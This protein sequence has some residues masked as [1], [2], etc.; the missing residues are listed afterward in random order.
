MLRKCLKW[1]VVFLLLA[2]IA[3]LRASIPDSLQQKVDSLYALIPTVSDS[4]LPGIINQS[5]K[6]YYNFF[7]SLGVPSYYDTD[8]PAQNIALLRQ[9]DTLAGF[10][11]DTS[12]WMQS[13]VLLTNY[14]FAD[15]DTSQKI[16]YFSRLKHLSASYGYA[17]SFSL[18][19]GLEEKQNEYFRIS[20]AIWIL[21][22]P[23]Q[24]WGI[25][26][27]LDDEQQ[28]DFKINPFK[29]GDDVA[30]R[31]KVYWGKLRLRGQPTRDDDYY[32]MAGFEAYS[33]RDI[34]IYIPDSLGHYQKS[35]SGFFTPIDEKP[36]PEWRNFFSVFVP[37]GGE[38]TI[39]WRL[40]EPTTIATPTNVL[41]FRTNR[42]QIQA[43]EA[44]NDHINGVFQ[45][46]VLIQGLFFLFW[47]FST[48][49][50]IYLSYV[51]YLLGLAFFT[52]TA[53]YFWVLFPQYP[54]FKE[55]LFPVTAFFI[56]SAFVLFSFS[57]LRVAERQHG[58]FWYKFLW[59]GLGL[60]FLM[61]LVS[62][63]SIIFQYEMGVLGDF[64]ERLGN[65]SLRIGLGVLLLFLIASGI[66]AIQAI[67]KGQKNAIYFLIANGVFI[68]GVGIPI[69]TPILAVEFVSFTA[70]IY[71]MQI[72]IIV[73][74]ALF[75]LAV[76]QQQNELEKDK[77]SALE[78]N[79]NLQK[80]INEATAKFVPYEFLRS[81]GRESILDVH[82]GDQVEKSVTVL[83]IDIRAYTTLSERMTPQE[84]FSFLN[85]YLGRVGP[86][87]KSNGGFVNQ[88][89]GDGIMALFLGKEQDAWGATIAIQ[90]ALQS[91][92]QERKIHQRLPIKVGM[93]LHTGPL[94]M[95]VI[96]DAERMEAGVVS[97]TVNT[98]SRME[99]LSKIF[100][101][102]LILSEST[103]EALRPEAKEYCRSLGQIQV[104]GKNTAI[105]IYEGALSEGSLKL[106]QKAD[107]LKALSA[108]SQ[109]DL[110]AAISIWES[111]IT[112]NPTDQAIS[113]Y[114]KRCRE[115]LLQNPADNWNPLIRLSS[116]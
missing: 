65:N 111:L 41:L 84:N 61:L 59:S 89:Y 52:L 54:D 46:V 2:P 55:V 83:F 10:Y 49:S 105:G 70:A 43:K 4:L 13:V 47:F 116:K 80:S 25:E 62:L 95:G 66:W 42:E 100:G 115:G 93:G 29:L 78:E 28:A 12:E 5:A 57:L 30:F 35:R 38:K 27:V 108:F 26:D 102:E 7:N 39:Y 16:K 31:E 74:L 53:N 109:G 60:M 36:L 20:H 50:K 77:R 58:R 90:A 114:L 96:G 92:N 82:L 69:L 68:F 72:S 81:L 18:G 19:A 22:D 48:R 67:R 45:G 71:S 88:Y 6:V 113:F 94:M 40:A 8:W 103:Y 86:L 1:C 110:S 75:G 24:S 21:E 87:I 76:G 97:D 17:L 91:Y 104:K 3:E 73:Q 99:G 23:S 15:P 98:A 101:A 56:A 37:R 63:Y 112:Q 32:F 9:A 51:F 106:A 107:F 44:Q 85:A 34:E 14:H 64:Y 79:L 11:A 33:W